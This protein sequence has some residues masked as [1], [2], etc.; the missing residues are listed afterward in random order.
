MKNHSQE[1]EKDSQAGTLSQVQNSEVKKKCTKK[2]IKASKAGRR[3]W[4]TGAS[5]VCV[6]WE[7]VNQEMLAT[8][9]RL[10]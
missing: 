2:W 1:G 3:Q 7:Q 10:R 8:N 6:V 5:T 9:Q 4:I